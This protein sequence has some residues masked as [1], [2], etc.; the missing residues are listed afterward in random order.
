MFC[1]L[2]LISLLTHY[3][4][5]Q[6]TKFKHR[7]DK[8]CKNVQA[9][10]HAFYL[11]HF[12]FHAADSGVYLAFLTFESSCLLLNFFSIRQEFLR[13]NQNTALFTVPDSLLM[14]KNE[15]LAQFTGRSRITILY[16]LSCKSSRNL[17]L[18]KSTLFGLGV[19]FFMILLAAFVLCIGTRIACYL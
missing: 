13:L 3:F 1:L 5:K 10:L 15:K 11:P 12:F 2:L 4:R 6:G 16:A 14:N 7:L 18:L 17:K 19:I 8:S 9:K